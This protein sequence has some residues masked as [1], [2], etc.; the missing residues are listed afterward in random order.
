MQE[1][2]IF[3]ENIRILEKGRMAEVIE[4]IEADSIPKAFHNV[5]KTQFVKIPQ[6]TY[7]NEILPSPIE[8]VFFSHLRTKQKEEV[9]AP[10][11]LLLRK[12]FGPTGDI[13]FCFNSKRVYSRLLMFTNFFR[14]GALLRSVDFF[15]D[16]TIYYHYNHKD[17]IRE[18]PFVCREYTEGEGHY[19]SPYLF[20]RFIET[21]KEEIERTREE[22]GKDDGIYSGLL[23]ERVE[24]T[25]SFIFVDD[26]GDMVGS[27]DGDLD[28]LQF[29]ISFTPHLATASVWDEFHDA[30]L[31]DGSLNV[32]RFSLA[33]GGKGET[34]IIYKE[35]DIE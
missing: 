25:C 11:R 14:L 7:L 26:S 19:P 20:G 23:R 12:L 16:G 34:P 30:D 10:A 29:P 21:A 5:L 2:N 6:G 8:I 17:G 1:L 28:D 33:V 18:G 31:E 35:L 13:P 4:S 15:S 3:E 32:D 24:S 22:W 9:A 27:Y